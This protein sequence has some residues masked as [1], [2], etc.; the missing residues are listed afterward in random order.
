VS[1]ETHPNLN[2]RDFPE[3]GSLIL[4]ALAIGLK[5][6][7]QAAEQD[8]FEGQEEEEMAAWAAR[9]LDLVI[10]GTSY[11]LRQ[12]VLPTPWQITTNVARHE[13]RKQQQRDYEA[14][15]KPEKPV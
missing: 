8:V 15:Q 3:P 2:P 12:N 14:S 7:Q 13:R 5:Y 6:T 4:E 10:A 9:W 11:H 1:D